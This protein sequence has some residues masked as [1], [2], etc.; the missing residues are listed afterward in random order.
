MIGVTVQVNRR[1]FCCVQR[2]REIIARPLHPPQPNKSLP[3]NPYRE[4]T[5]ETRTSA[6]RSKP[7]DLLRIAG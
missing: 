2:R 3:H 4:A 5:D 6:F 1:S 7:D